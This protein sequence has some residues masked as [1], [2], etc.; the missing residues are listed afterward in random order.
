MLQPAALG[1]L[2][3]SVAVKVLAAGGD[4]AMILDRDGVI[5][6]VAVGNTDLQLD[7]F[8]GWVNKPWLDTVTQECRP[9][10]K[11]MLRDAAED[12]AIRWR[13]LNHPSRRGDSVPLRYVALGAGEDGRIIAIGRDHRAASVLQQRLLQAQQ[14]MER[15][16]ARMRLSESRYRMLFQSTGEAVLVV[17][18]ATRR[19]SE[20][21]IAADR[22]IDGDGTLVGKSFAKLFASQCQDDA[23]SLL[24]IAQ[25]TANQS[26][27]QTNLISNGRML[28]VTA[29][30]FR[31]DRSTHFLVRLLPANP[32]EPALGDASQRVLKAINLL[33]DGFVVT[34]HELTILTQNIAFLDMVNLASAAQAQGISLSRFLGRPGVDR[35]ILLENLTKHGMVRNF[36]TVVQTQFGE[37]E[38]VEICAVSVAEGDSSFFGFSIRRVSRRDVERGPPNLEIVR[39]P[40]DMSELV[41][42]VSLKEIVRDTTDFVERLCIEAALELT[43]NNRAS[44]A[45]ILGV[46]RQSLYSKLHRFGI[47]NFEDDGQ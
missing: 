25:A 35:N 15:D 29:S 45:E 18:G 6:D 13:E 30:L 43:G 4:V 32:L 14:S 31:Q 20:A 28:Q 7:D 27:Q 2:E 21:N 36:P 26:G 47:G 22:L 37:V 19:V 38:D 33:P 34:D 12:K 10:V 42:R 39:S 16:Y 9:K 44:A 17:D 46:S 3:A 5:C 23:A 11:E 1:D 40:A 41:G 24:S 8:E